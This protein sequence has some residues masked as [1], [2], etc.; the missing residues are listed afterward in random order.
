MDRFNE[1]IEDWEASTEA[2]NINNTYVE[3]DII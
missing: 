2:D 3:G 1:M